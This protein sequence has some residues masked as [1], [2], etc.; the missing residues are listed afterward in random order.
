MKSVRRKVRIEK[1]EEKKFETILGP[2]GFNLVAEGCSSLQELEKLAIF[3][4]CIMLEVYFM[5]PPNQV[6][7]GPIYMVIIVHG[8]LL[9][10][11]I[12]HYCGTGKK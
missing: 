10:T 9:G 12:N 4:V 6:Y 7:L 2:K 11:I 8:I 1:C 3:L 5:S